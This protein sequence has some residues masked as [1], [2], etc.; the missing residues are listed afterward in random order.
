MLT[1]LKKYKDMRSQAKTIQS[2][3]ADESV[4]VKSANGQVLL[5][6]DGNMKI[7]GLAIDDDM[8]SPTKKEQLQDAIKKAHE[9]ATKKIQRVMAVKMKEMGGIPGLTG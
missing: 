9:E 5:T 7:T 2:A 3:L 4:T 6:M 1:K 8:M